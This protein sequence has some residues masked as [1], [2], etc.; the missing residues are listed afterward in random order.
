MDR[1]DAMAMFVATVDQGSLAGAARVFACSPAKVTR[2]LQM[3]EERLGERL[4]HRNARRLRLTD[5]GERRLAVYRRVLAELD[6]AEGGSGGAID[7]L[8]G[9]TAPE[10][11]G[12]LHVVPVIETF[13]AEHPAA[14]ARA[15]LLNRMVDLVEEGMDVAVRLA[16]LPDS[17]IVATRLGEVRKLV[18]AAPSYVERAGAPANPIELQKHACVGEEE[19]DA[20][21]LW[22][23][24]EPGPRRR[25]TFAVAIRPRMALNSAGAA[26]DAAVRGHGVCRALSYQVAEHVAAGRLVTLLD[27]FEPEPTPV[28]LVFHPVPRRN[29]TLRAFIDHAAPR[30]RETLA[31]VARQIGETRR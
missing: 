27:A 13:L 23:F 18:C 9:V 11:F 25:K 7:G 17:G 31:G 6:A 4:V 10:L 1:L 24:A 12:R 22:R 26:I 2:A 16:P 20:G 14:R 3:L 15:L 5:A 30:L 19:G 8:I 29:E 28:S 21:A